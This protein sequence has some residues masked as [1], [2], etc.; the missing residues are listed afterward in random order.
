MSSPSSAPQQQG[1]HRSSSSSISAFVSTLVPCVA[2]AAVYIG[3][4]ISD[5]R[6]TD[7]EFILNHQSLDGYLYMRFFKMM[8]FMSC[9]DCLIAW[10]VL[11]PVNATGGARQS[12]LD[13][14]S[15]TF[16]LYLIWRELLYVIK[17]RQ[18]YLLTAWNASRISSRTVLFTNVPDEY[19]TH[20]HLEENVDD[21]TQTALKLENGD[22]KLIQKSVKQAMK[23]KKGSGTESMDGQARQPKLTSWDHFVSSKDRPTHRL[24]LLIGHK[25]DTI[26][27][28]KDHLKELLL[29]VQA[30]Q[31]SHIAGKEKIVES[32]QWGILPGEIIWGN[33]KM[34]A[35]D[36]SLRRGVAT[37]FICA[38]TL[39]W[40]IPVALVGIISNVNYLTENV[41]FLRWTDDIPQVILGVITGLLP[42]VLL[43]VLMSLVP[44]IFAAKLSG[45]ISLSEIKQQ[46]QTWYFAF[47]VNQVFLITT[48]TSGATA[49]ASQIVSD[50]TQAVPLLAQNLPKASNFYI[51]Y[52]VFF[53][54]AQVVNYLFKIGG[55]IGVFI[56]NKLAGTPRKKYDKWMALSAP[57]W[58][59]EDPKWTNLGVIAISYAIIAPLLTCPDMSTAPGSTPKAPATRAMQQLMVGVYLAKFCLLGLFAIN[60]GDSA[61]AVGPVVLQVVLIIVTIMCHIAMRKKLVPLVDKLPLNLLKE[62][63]RRSREQPE[64]I[65]GSTRRESKARTDRSDMHPGYEGKNEIITSGPDGSGLVSGSAAHF[66][67]DS[68][69]NQAAK[70]D[71][72]NLSSRPQKPSLFRRIFKPQSQSAAELS[73]SLNPRFREPLARDSLGV[74]AREVGDLKEKLSEYGVYATD[75]SAVV[76]D[77]GKVEWVEDKA[78]EAPLWEDR[79]VY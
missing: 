36:R 71:I 16:V 69:R 49:V 57:S 59:S 3:V 72:A 75:E 66:S 28:G 31:R 60:I 58:G 1:S 26:D 9:V 42:T 15:F 11:F 23:D 64:S 52:L 61:V 67:T 77:K 10:P 43:A 38:M 6:N 79:V 22:M 24:K 14:L 18:A 55:I 34:N 56:L 39:F 78:K 5:Y 33:L 45:A 70:E 74:S 76:N 20:R 37:T 65:G 27:Y 50:P 13:I 32:R 7:D 44:I 46:T 29:E 41:P 30:S 63:E 51:S 4:F 35:W 54:V 73:A 25:V 53:G 12:N 47:Q 62:S 68:Y 2:L 8:V 21:I 40:S 19:L 17:L 48:F